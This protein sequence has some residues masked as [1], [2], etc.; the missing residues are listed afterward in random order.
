[1]SGLLSD[2]FNNS[3]PTDKDKNL[4]N[5]IFGNQTCIDSPISEFFWYFGLPILATFLFCLLY[6]AEVDNLSK[7]VLFFIVVLLLDW[8]FTSWKMDH[9]LFQ[10]I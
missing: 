1:M 4:L 3:P 6:L 7:V 8:S 9:P 10:I 5:L 2:P